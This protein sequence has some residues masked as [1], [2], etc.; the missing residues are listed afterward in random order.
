MLLTHDCAANHNNN[1]I[2]KFADDTSIVG[3]IT[4]GDESAYRDQVETLMTW[5]NSHNLPL[6]TGITK[7]IIDFRRAQPIHYP[8]LNICGSIAERVQSTKFLRIHINEDLTSKEN[9]SAIVTKAE[10]HLHLLRRLTRT[11]LSKSALTVFYCGTIESIITY[12]ITSWCGNSRGEERLSSVVKTAKRISGSPLSQLMEIYNKRCHT[13]RGTHHR[14]LLS[15]LSWPLFSVAVRKEIQ[16]HSDT[17]IPETASFHQLSGCWMHSNNPWLSVTIM[18]F[19][20]LNY[21][22]H[23]WSV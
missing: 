17:D 23:L 6:N 12:C 9:N 8:P 14:G 13:Q 1:H 18:H 2:I 16:Q 22:F 15:S 19:I 7:E 20:F 5:W 4:N 21:L 3:I 10:Q 11:G